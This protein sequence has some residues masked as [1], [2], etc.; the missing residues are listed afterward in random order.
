MTAKRQTQKDKFR[1]FVLR[2]VF[3]IQSPGLK[4]STVMAFVHGVRFT[5][6]Y[7][8][9][10][11]KDLAKT[12]GFVYPLPE[13]EYPRELVFKYRRLYPNTPRLPGGVSFLISQGSDEDS[14]QTWEV[15]SGWSHDE[16]RQKLPE[17]TADFYWG[18]PGI[19][20]QLDRVDRDM[21]TCFQDWKR[22]CLG[23]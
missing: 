10:V 14:P 7:V 12:L 8:P 5:G 16:V 20:P 11:T 6:P 21:E 13:P 9:Q 15:V 3:A 4:G 23:T 18:E 19:F 22:K 2:T 17:D 1:E